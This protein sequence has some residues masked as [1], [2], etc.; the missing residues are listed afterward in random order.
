MNLSYKN[1][2]ADLHDRG[3]SASFFV[4]FSSKRILFMFCGK[5]EERKVLTLIVR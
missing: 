3:F 5:V 1:L 2:E 4:L